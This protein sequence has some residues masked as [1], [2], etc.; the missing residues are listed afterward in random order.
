MGDRFSTEKKKNATHTSKARGNKMKID[1]L[2][3]KRKS[4]GPEKPQETVKGKDEIKLSDAAKPLPRVSKIVK[5]EPLGHLDNTVKQSS[6]SDAPGF[7]GRKRRAACSITSY[8][9]LKLGTK[10]RRGDPHTSHYCSSDK[11]QI[12]KSPKLKIR[13]K[14][15]RTSG[16]ALGTLNNLS[17][18]EDD[19]EESINQE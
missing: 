11:I 15:H 17:V 12:Y 6:V 5:R 7:E 3:N 14:S 9:E 2:D 8:A 18:R 4:A 16:Q 13:H 1:D 10:L 19:H